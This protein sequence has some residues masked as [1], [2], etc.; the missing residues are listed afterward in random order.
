MCVCVLAQVN[1]RAY[2]S[3]KQVQLSVVHC[4]YYNAKEEEE[5]DHDDDDDDEEQVD[6]DEVKHCFEYLESVERCS[7]RFSL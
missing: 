6:G 5:D 2:A 1:R 4:I 7:Y 3:I